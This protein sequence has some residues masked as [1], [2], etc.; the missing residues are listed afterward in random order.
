M[1]C[2][3]ASVLTILFEVW[4]AHEDNGVELAASV[5]YGHAYKIEKVTDKQGV[6]AHVLG[7]FE[8]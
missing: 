5:V 3:S 8:V 1:K 6:K 4:I 7:S 2:T